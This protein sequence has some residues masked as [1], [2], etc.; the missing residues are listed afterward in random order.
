LNC[1]SCGTGY[2]CSGGKCVSSDCAIGPGATF[3]ALGKYYADSSTGAP[4]TSRTG[5][6]TFYE[7][8]HPNSDRSCPRS[9]YY[10]CPPGSQ[11]NFYYNVDTAVGGNNGFDGYNSTGYLYFE[12]GGNSGGYGWRS[13]YNQNSVSFQFITDDPNT[14]GYWGADVQGIECLAP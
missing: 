14:D 1:G 2:A 9:P 11:I 6:Y 5:E 3:N 4:S 13:I 8:K 7:T 10:V 12:T